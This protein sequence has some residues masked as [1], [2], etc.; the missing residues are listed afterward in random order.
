MEILGYVV[1]GVLIAGFGWALVDLLIKIHK[2]PKRPLNMLRMTSY[3]FIPDDEI[4]ERMREETEERS[5]GKLQPSPVPVN[6]NYR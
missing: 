2:Q 6:S 4:L 1:Y 5:A 3:P